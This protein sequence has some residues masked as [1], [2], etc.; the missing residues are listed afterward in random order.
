M[1]VTNVTFEEWLHDLTEEA[2]AM[3]NVAG[4][5]DVPDKELLKVVEL[6]RLIPQLFDKIA[7]GEQ[8]HRDWLKAAI[9]AH[10]SGNPMPEYVAK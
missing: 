10:F 6:V 8:G 7:H 2:E 1:T 5:R 3:A 4:G 9:E